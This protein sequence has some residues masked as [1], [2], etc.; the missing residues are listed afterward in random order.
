[1]N[2]LI[3]SPGVADE[4]SAATPRPLSVLLVANRQQ[5]L[6]QLIK[7]V[8]ARANFRLTARI[9]PEAD[10]H[11]RLPDQPQDIL[12]LEQ[13]LV[14]AAR[15]FGHTRLAETVFGDLQQRFPGL[16]IV[17]FGSDMDDVLVRRMIRLGVRGLVDITAT[18]PEQLALA[19][20]EIHSGGYWLARGALEQLIH[21]AVDVERLIERGFVE[22]IAAM[23]GGLTRR[24]TDVLE[25]VLDGM[26]TRE[27]AGQMFLSEQGVKM[28]LGRLFKK[29]GVANRA[30][31]ILSAFQR[32]C[33]FNRNM[34]NYFRQSRG[35][36]GL[37]RH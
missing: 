19:I 20:D 26:S 25:R 37:S 22:Q 9:D 6:D 24:E 11:T 15:P 10:W 27:I 36:R 28:H 16:R 4:P 3:H 23:Q 12:L 33:P 34:V 8:S 2:H 14:S 32:V 17:V 1:M 7:L 30:Q 18:D 13:S 5:H 31:L 29:F 35:Q 21:S